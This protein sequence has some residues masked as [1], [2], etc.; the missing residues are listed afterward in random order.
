MY[1]RV[2]SIT[3][4]CSLTIMWPIIMLFQT[5]L[6]A[7]HSFTVFFFFCVP[8]GRDFGISSR[9]LF[10]NFDSQGQAMSSVGPSLQ[11]WP[12]PS[13]LSSWLLPPFLLMADLL[14]QTRVPGVEVV[15]GRLRFL[16]LGICDASCW[17]TT[18]QDTFDVL[19]R[20]SQILGNPSDLGKP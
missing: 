15:K 1:K 17:L 6:L 5:I 4:L 9:Y 14:L 10:Q 2:T 3:E 11:F 13:L 8:S 12:C 18:F 16:V 20:I 19:A 7:S